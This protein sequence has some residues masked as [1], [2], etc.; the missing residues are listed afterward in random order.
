MTVDKDV[1]ISI[2]NILHVFKR[3][4]EGMSMMK[5]MED[6]KKTQT[7]LLEGKYTNI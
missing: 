1:K 3:E 4:K 2:I 5:E 6:I 7:E